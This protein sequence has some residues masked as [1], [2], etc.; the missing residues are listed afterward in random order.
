MRLLY[1]RVALR[2][3]SPEKTKGGLFIPE[4]ARDKVFTG[5]VIALGKGA[6]DSNGERIP[7]ELKVG[8]RVVVHKFIN[9]NATE[10]ELN[11]EKCI[12]VRERDC[13]LKCN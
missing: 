11:G 7:M 6:F 3:I 1:D 9:M 12:I 10:T 13:L 4:I 2:M 5:E 8:D